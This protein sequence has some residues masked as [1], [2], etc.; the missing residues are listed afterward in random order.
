MSSGVTLDLDPKRKRVI[1]W[2]VLG[3]I[4]VVLVIIAA[5]VFSHA[6]TNVQASNKADQLQSKLTAA[7]LP[8]PDKNQIVRVLGNDGG[9]MCHDP[10]SGLEQAQLQQQMYNG[11]DGP[12]ARPTISDVDVVQGE[13]I[14]LSI[15]CP[16]KVGEFT[17]QVKN[18]YKFDDVIRN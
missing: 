6:K 18:N 5:A 7:G 16:E 13:L 9:A 3:A 2:I 1:T 8:V 12:G 15:Y 14:A 11:A 10:S 17:Q 4:F